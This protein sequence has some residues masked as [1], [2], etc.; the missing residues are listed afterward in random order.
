MS[1]VVFHNAKYYSLLVATGI[2]MFSCAHEVPDE[3]AAAYQ[4]LPEQIDFNY[5]VKPILSDKCF[6][7]HGPDKNTRKA[8]FRLDTEE[9][10][11]SKLKEGGFA[12]IAGNPSQSIAIQKILSESP[13]LRMPP[14]ESHL[15]LSKLEIAIL[16]KWVDQGA[17]WKKHW[18]L[19]QPVKQP[20]PNGFPENWKTNNE[21]DNFILKRIQAEGL[22]PSL[23]ADKERLL[24][25]VTIDLT[26][27]P[28]NIEEIDAFLSDSSPKAYEK[29]VDR[30]LNT[31]AHAE[32]LTLEWLDVARYADSHGMH[33]DGYRFMWPWRDW[34]IAAFRDN[35]SYDK[36]VTLQL[37]G[38]LLPNATKDQI[39]ATAFNRN[40]PMTDEGGVIDEEFRLKYVADRT[41]TTATAFLGLTIEC[42]SCHDH[43]FDPISQKEFYQ[44][45][46]FFNNVKELGMTGADG[47]YGPNLL[48]TDTTTENHIRQIKD[49]IEEK[50]KEIGMENNHL[51]SSAY[52]NVSSTPMQGL[53]GHYPIESYAT[54]SA[55]TNKYSLDNNHRSTTKSRPVFEKGADGKGNALKLTGEYDELYLFDVGYFELYDPFSAGAWI[56]TSKKEPNKTQTIFGN[57]GQKNNFWRGWDFFLDQSNRINFRLVHSLPHNYLQVVSK[58]SI[59]LNQWTHVMFTYDGSGKAAGV[60]LYIDGKRVDTIASFDRLYKTILPIKIGTHLPDNRPLAVGKSYRLHTGEFGI[61]KGLID[62]IHIFDKELVAFEVNGIVQQVK[63]V[64]PN[65]YNSESLIAEYWRRNAPIVKRKLSELKDLRKE[66]L[67]VIEPIDEVMVMEELPT[68]RKTFVLERGE[69]NSPGESVTVGTPEAILPFSEEYPSNRL[70]L[71]KWLFDKNNPLTARVTVNRY[72]N[73]IFGR[74]L[75]KSINDFGSQGDLPSHPELLDWLA[76]EF[77]ESGWDVRS[78]LKRIVMSATYQQSAIMRKDLLESDP[79]NILLARSPS[80]R[81]QAEVIRDIA[82]ASS[83]LLTIQV[84]GPSAK[85]YQPEGLWTNIYSRKLLKYNQDSGA[86]LYRRSMYTFIRRTSP[87][88]FMAIFDAP[89]RDVC[90]VNRERT[91]T[92]LQALVLLNDPQFVEASKVLAERSFRLGGKQIAEQIKYAFRIVTSRTPS[93]EEIDILVRLYNNE[94]KQFNEGKIKA[95]GL[96]SVG[97]YGV[98]KV[99]DKSKL[100]SMTMVTNTILNHDEAYMRR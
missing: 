50:E 67:S 42:A 29:V 17:E 33:A 49:Y 97:D 85:P 20:I 83:G 22:T 79:E 81:F 27:L 19:I 88:P 76:V 56:T 18:S 21:I 64:I 26:G 7:C 44:L 84:G 39:I 37:A 45:S 28:P 55:D 6:H 65:D 77:R 96:L 23:P 75:V 70:G 61:F 41:I 9:G 71:S 54:T 98:D 2:L 15:A 63:S 95:N 52:A 25:R 13:E 3:I 62:E 68:P 74:G 11:F 86:Y 46:A 80:Y 38:D 31:D 57:T 51:I 93:N 60:K 5:H 94:L 59:E 92:P 4:D 73:M 10:A 72:W 43:K 16:H 47:N 78:L 90:T 8:E 30:L 99:Y 89:N 32:R 35:M 66:L 34:V 36:F 87:P 40:H 12:F 14:L 58:D 1:Q 48:L 100:A 24:R 69:Y 53:V 82:L 91:N